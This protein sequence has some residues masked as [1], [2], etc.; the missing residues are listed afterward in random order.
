MD[1]FVIHNHPELRTGQMLWAKIKGGITNC[2][3]KIFQPNIIIVGFFPFS[4][5][6]YS[7]LFI[8]SVLIKFRNI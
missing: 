5:T 2:S 4:Y 7:A 3:H 1:I 8:H 6:T